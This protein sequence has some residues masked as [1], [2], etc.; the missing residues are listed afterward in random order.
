MQR[1]RRMSPESPSHR[2]VSRLTGPCAALLLAACQTPPSQ[3]SAAALPPAALS[4]DTAAY[5]I[6]HARCDHESACGTVGAGRT[7]PDH[8]QC[9]SELLRSAQIDLA[10]QACPAGIAARRVEDCA[11]RLRHESCHPLSTLSRMYACRPAA[12]CL[13][14]SRQF[15]TEEVY[16]E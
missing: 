13:D 14:T 7:Y 2:L 1:L 16:S 8:D 5:E 11:G 3:T 12:L 4:A 6:A 9:A 15:S 10:T